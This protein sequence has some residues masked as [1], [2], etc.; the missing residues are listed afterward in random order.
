MSNIRF[1][2]LFV[3]A[4]LLIGG[5]TIANAQVEPGEALK[6]DVSH[7][8]VVRDKLFPAGEYTI[9]TIDEGDGSTHLLK[10]QSENGKQFAVFDTLGKLLNEPS[11]KTELLFDQVGGEYILTGIRVQGEDQAS[12]VLGS[13]SERRDAIAAAVN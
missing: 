10:L 9:T 3:F 7:P 5:I 11:K 12:Q 13:R 6:G 2:I 4:F 1:Q 8:F